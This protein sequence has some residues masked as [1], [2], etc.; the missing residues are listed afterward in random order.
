MNK[1]LR[2]ILI[3]DEDFCR[4]DLAE[5]LANIPDIE[6][7]AEASSLKEAVALI[8]KH[9]PDLIFLDLNLRGDN[10]FQILSE[11]PKTPSIIAVTAFSEHAVEGFSLDLADYI[12][13]PVEEKRLKKAIERAREDILQKALKKAALLELEISGK[14]SSVPISEVYAVK[15]NQNYVEV[16]SSCGTGLIR[17]TFTQLIG[18]FPPNFILEISRGHALARHQVNGWRRDS[19]GHL[20]I[21][22]KTGGEF[23]VSKRL[24][25][26]VLRHL[27]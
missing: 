25:K 14:S 7:T 16:H 17:S 6:I 13:K 9:S 4:N 15:S 24:Q 12:L 18:R 20:L 19:S 11:I 23:M 26:E 1:I 27:S 8:T 5:V 22:L 3:D 21:R 2:A 10:G